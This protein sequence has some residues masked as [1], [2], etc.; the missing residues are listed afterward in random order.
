[1][2]NSSD[3]RPWY[4]VQLAGGGVLLGVLLLPQTLLGQAVADRLQG[5]LWGGLMLPDGNALYEIR[6]AENR[7]TF[8]QR[9]SVATIQGAGWL[10]G[11]SASLQPEGWPVRV[12]GSIGQARGMNVRIAGGTKVPGLCPAAPCAA[13]AVWHSGLTVTVAQLDALVSPLEPIGPLHSRLLVGMAGHYRAYKSPVMAESWGTP[14]PGDTVATKFPSNSLT[15]ALHLGPEVAINAL[16][17]S[18]YARFGDYISMDARTLSD[19]SAEPYFRHTFYLS[20]G[21]VLN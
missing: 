6:Q 9:F 15:G 7:G 2:R 12:R 5:G 13:G 10:I 17:V 20:V 11:G 16:G 21:T 8:P 1:M 3:A 19:G 4:W 18:L 14:A